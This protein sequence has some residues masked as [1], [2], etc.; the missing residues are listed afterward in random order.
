[1]EQ[2]ASTADVTQVRREMF[3]PRNRSVPRGQRANM[4]G[5]VLPLI[6]S[7]LVGAAAVR[8]PAPSGD[9]CDRA[10]LVKRPDEGI[11]HSRWR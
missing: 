6:G 3:R 8:L 10:A 1:M 4:L 5:D 9:S 2:P 7:D 11:V